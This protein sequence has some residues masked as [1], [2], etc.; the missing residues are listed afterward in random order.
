MTI[1]TDLAVRDLTD[2]AQGRHAIQLVV[3]AVLDAVTTRWPD[4]PLVIHRGDRIVDVA[5]NYDRLGYDPSAAARDSRYTRYVSPGR[6]L[7]S[8]TSALIPGALRALT[9]REAIVACPGIVYRRDAIDR[10]HTGTPHQLDL[11]LVAATV[12]DLRELVSVGLGAAIPGVSWRATAAEHPYTSGGLEIEARS[13][14]GWIEVGECGIAADHVLRRPGMAGLALGLG[15]DRLLM[16]RKGIDDI[17]LLRSADP[18]V[19]A[20]MTDLLPYRP[21]SRHPAAWRDLS[22]ALPADVTVEEVGDRVRRVLGPDAALVEEVTIRSVTLAADLPAAS[23]ERLRLRAGEANVLLRVVL[24][25]LR[26][27]LPKQRVNA[28]RDRL[29]RELAEQNS[30]PSPRG[31][32]Q[33]SSHEVQE[34]MTSRRRA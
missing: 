5:D 33:S 18:R 12:P 25:D 17:R 34:A 32:V 9:T 1:T 24:R 22:V 21:V 13:P 19:V 6:M 2:P 31:R 7:R 4:L 20:Q 8:Q 30:G 10:L 29:L 3:A 16:V 14:G 26:S 23:R 11:W 15:L 27:A 28:L